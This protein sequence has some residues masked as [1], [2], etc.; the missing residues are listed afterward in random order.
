MN[1]VTVGLRAA[2]VVSSLEI[3]AHECGSTADEAGRDGGTRDLV[4]L[5]VCFNGVEI[6]HR[7]FDVG[8]GAQHVRLQ[9]TSMSGSL[10][11]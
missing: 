2:R 4:H 5:A 10:A 8:P 1:L 9:K 3:L 6:V 7:Q 11:G